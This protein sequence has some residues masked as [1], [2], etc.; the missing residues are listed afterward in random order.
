MKSQTVSGTGFVYI[1]NVRQRDVLLCI[2]RI[3]CFPF[4]A[5]EYAW[6][7]KYSRP[8][9]DEDSDFVH[10]EP[11]VCR[12]SHGILYPPNFVPTYKLPYGRMSPYKIPY[13]RMYLPVTRGTKY[14][15]VNCPPYGILSPS[16][17]AL[18]FNLLH[19]VVILQTFCSHTTYILHTSGIL[20]ILCAYY[21]AVVTLYTSHSSI[22]SNT[23]QYYIEC[24][25]YKHSIHCAPNKWYTLYILITLDNLHSIYY[26][27]YTMY[28][29]HSM[30]TVA[31]LCTM[32]SILQG[33]YIQCVLNPHGSL[34]ML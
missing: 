30:N 24:V 21:H 26:A 28:L 4:F 25:V 29:T 14:H 18:F 34:R 32:H 15:M 31:I 12:V 17:N 9:V 19:I 3:Q 27:F 33:H 5:R 20:R 13:G 10:T 11:P 2:S 22:Y 6:F 8:G 1:P 7:D 16:S 23:M